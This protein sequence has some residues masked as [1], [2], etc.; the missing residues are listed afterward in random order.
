MEE[1]ANSETSASILSLSLW[2]VKTVNY[3][4]S[5]LHVPFLHLILEVAL[6]LWIVRLMTTKSY[7][8]KETRLELSKEEEDR[9]IAE[10]QPEPLVPEDEKVP[11][12]VS[13][14]KY[15]EGKPGYKITIDGKE[16][17]NLCT[18]NFLGLVGNKL[19]EDSTIE[20]LR[21][22][23]VGTCGPRGFY[24]TIDV[25]L[26]LEEKIASY[27]GTEEAILYSY[28]FATVSSAIP[29]Y[30][31]RTDVIFCDSGV[32]FAIQKGISA[33]RSKVYWFNHNDMDDLESKLKEQEE[34]DAKNP[35]KAEVTRRFLVVEGI[36][37]NYGDVAP[38]PKIIELKNKYKVR[39]FIDET[40]SFG[41]L[42]SHGRGVTEHFG[43]PL[44]EI[45]LMAVSLEASLGSVGG[46]CAGSSFVVDH[47]RL[48]GQGYCFSASLPPLLSV[49]AESGLKIMEENNDM[50]GKLKN[51]A[52][53]LRKELE[54]I[55]GM[56]V[57]G[58]DISPII[59]LRFEERNENMTRQ[60]EEDKLQSIVNECMEKG[61]GLTLSRYLNDLELFLPKAS[62]RVAVNIN[63]T[64]EDIKSSVECIKNAARSLLVE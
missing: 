13:E 27:L 26:T 37:M 57:E 49:A 55:E 61:V 24:G 35:K 53:S 17:L 38:L 12:Y 43:I 3:V 41:V 31:K 48:S 62:I 25:H 19:I 42:G 30:S 54:G 64:E 50:F 10:W 16:C 51:N 18:L 9:L 7:K 52:A 59:H 15:I 22:Y 46:F 23:G 14:P 1:A 56:V 34:K 21:K 58:D 20:T 4:E 40:I 2:V 44:S 36:Y 28:G 39:V 29:A 5:T 60:E 6:V 33:S 45:D 47:Q 63:L 8:P 11:H 32:S